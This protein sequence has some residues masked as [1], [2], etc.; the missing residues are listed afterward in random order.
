MKVLRRKLNRK[1]V[2]PVIATLLMIAIAVAA[3]ILVYVWS[4][5]LVGSLQG[6]GGQQTKE[7]LIVEA[8]DATDTASPY[9]WT[10]RIRNVGPATSTI[11][12]VYVEGQ[13]TTLSGTTTYSP[14]ASGSLTITFSAPTVTNGMAYTVKIVTTSGAVF[15]ISV[16]AGRAA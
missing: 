13:P 16:I 4:M 3:S 9:G 7:Q 2:S 5:G 15:S 6:T 1:A 11:A 8:Y 12:A 14:G 10:L